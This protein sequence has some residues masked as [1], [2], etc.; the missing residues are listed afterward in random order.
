MSQWGGTHSELSL[1]AWSMGCAPELIPDLILT[2]LSLFL[3]LCSAFSSQSITC[4]TQRRDSVF[5]VC[6]CVC[7]CAVL[8]AHPSKEPGAPRRLFNSSWT[9]QRGTEHLFQEVSIALW[10]THTHTHTYS[11]T[12]GQNIQWLISYV[13]SYSR[14]SSQNR[15]FASAAYLFFAPRR[16]PHLSQSFSSSP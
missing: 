7:V 14:N 2:L 1:G 12:H 15:A 13:V 6:V 4:N 11:H 16:R 5:S 8:T 3:C 10:H 9:Q